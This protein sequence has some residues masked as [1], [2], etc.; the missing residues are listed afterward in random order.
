M[1]GKLY[2]RYI[3]TF[4]RYLSKVGTMSY[5]N[6]KEH[7]SK[8][9]NTS[10]RQ[11]LPGQA[12]LNLIPFFFLN[13]INVMTKLGVTSTRFLKSTQE[14]RAIVNCRLKDIYLCP[15]QISRHFQNLTKI[16]GLTLYCYNIRQNSTEA[17]EITEWKTWNWNEEENCQWFF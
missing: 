17:F 10:Y 2:A 13:N 6:T 9:E 5:Q 14:K 15:F 1:C 7:A 4:Q 11:W 16:C 3:L 12:V 8:A